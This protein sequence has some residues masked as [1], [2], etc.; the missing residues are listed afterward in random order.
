MKNWDWIRLAKVHVILYVI[1][2]YTKI[3]GCCFTKKPQNVNS[4]CPERAGKDPALTLFIIF[5]NLFTLL[6]IR[7]ATI[8]TITNRIRTGVLTQTCDSPRSR[9]YRQSFC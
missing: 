4:S 9:N 6:Y 5:W 1:D 8:E 2:L 7:A 3:A